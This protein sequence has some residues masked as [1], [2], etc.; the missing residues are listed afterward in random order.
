MVQQK[1]SVVTPERFARG[2]TY[3]EYV[4]GIERNKQRFE[5]NYAE[6]SVSAEDVAAFK[7]LMALP[8]GPAKV[9]VIGEDWCPDVFRGMPV[10]ARLA[11][12]TGLE[13]RIFKRDENKDIM[14][15]FLKDG[16]FESIPVAV[17]YTTDMT[18]LTHFI[19]RP[20][21][22]NEEMRTTLRPMYE[23][24]RKPDMTDAER[25]AMRE[26][27]IAF[28]HGPIWANWR[29]ETVRQCLAALREKLGA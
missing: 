11:E 16:E 9:L 18:Y 15:E 5:E 19:E 24:F 17:F 25:A 1:E 4:A 13:L 29:Q 8:G 27:N 22:A 14:S 26:E 2:L 20:A 28:Q 3:A 10:F 7:A 12:A 23:R 21:L 6:M